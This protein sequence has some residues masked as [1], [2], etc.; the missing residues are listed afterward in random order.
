MDEARF[1][2]LLLANFTWPT[3]YTFKFVVPTARVEALYRLFADTKIETRSS[4]GGRYTSVTARPLM[5][6]PDA[7]IG[8]YHLAAEIEGLLAL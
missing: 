4:S 7:V 1:R 8:I 6:S 5:E 2:E 3:Q